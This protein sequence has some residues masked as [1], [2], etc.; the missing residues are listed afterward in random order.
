MK[1]ALLMTTILL[2]N[3]AHAMGWFKPHD[4]W[5][6]PPTQERPVAP[7]LDVSAG[8]LALGLVVVGLALVR[9]RNKK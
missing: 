5:Q 4:G 3:N 9:E 2:A 7:E 8:G 1:K 6:K